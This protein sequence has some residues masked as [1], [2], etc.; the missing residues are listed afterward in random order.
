MSGSPGLTARPDPDNLHDPD[1]RTISAKRKPADLLQRSAGGLGYRIVV[2]AS[3][4]RPPGLV[5]GPY[6]DHCARQKGATLY[7]GV[8]TSQLAG[9]LSDVSD[10]LGFRLAGVD[11]QATHA[12]DGST[13]SLVNLEAKKR[14]S[15]TPQ[16]VGG[17]SA[18]HALPLTWSAGESAS[19][20][21]CGKCRRRT[22]YGWFTI[23][24][25]CQSHKFLR[26]SASQSRN[27]SISVVLVGG[28]SRSF[29]SSPAF[30]FPSYS[31]CRGFSISRVPAASRQTI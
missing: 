22:S 7:V 21:H 1:N 2:S 16:R 17:Q 28:Y 15:Y 18:A 9:R 27:L 23:C 20:P 10:W 11:L 12:R 8:D 19:V 30:H 31:I 4:A 29:V 3:W 14:L 26:L 13:T 24:A 5:C 6:K 25:S